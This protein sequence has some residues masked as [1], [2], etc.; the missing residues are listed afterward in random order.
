[1]F[2]QEIKQYEEMLKEYKEKVVA[3]FALQ[4]LKEYNEILFSAHSCAIEGN[5]FSVDD[6]R[7]LKEQGL[8]MIPH[9][10]S[11]YEAFEILDHFN[12]YEFLMSCT[13]QPL[14]EDIVKETHRILTNH[15]LR[16]RYPD[17]IPGEYTTTDMGAGDTIF[18]DHEIN[19]AKVPLLLKSTQ[20]AMAH[21]SIHPIELSAQFHRHFIFLHPFRDG[22]GRL[23][24]LLSNFILL[25]LGHPMLIIESSDKSEYINALRVCKDTH[26]TAAI[27]DF[28]FKT[29]IKRME[30][31]LAQKRQMNAEETDYTTF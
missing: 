30:K 31:E 12:A 14:T 18:G 27:V 5:T 3:R 16:F 1:M 19:I 4:D 28:F 23:G 8:G 25:K 13:A 17:A 7:A 10:K 20:N 29:A 15:T 2:A 6:T 22:N 9:G 26:N 24:R 11:L 21:P